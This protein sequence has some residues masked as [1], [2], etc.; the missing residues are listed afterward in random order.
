MMAAAESGTF[1]IPTRSIEMSHTSG[2]F[3][4][5]LPAPTIVSQTAGRTAGRLRYNFHCRPINGQ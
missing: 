2:D 3:D 4:P 5:K 1:F